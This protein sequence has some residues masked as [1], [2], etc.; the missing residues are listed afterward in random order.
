MYVLG[1]DPAFRSGCKLA[2]VDETGK[3]HEVSVIFPHP[4]KPEKEKSK[5]AILSLIKKVSSFN[6]CDWEWYSIS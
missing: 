2:I 1:V 4:P 6:Y 5:H 3:L